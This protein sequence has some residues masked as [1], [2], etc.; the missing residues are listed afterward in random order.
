VR[1]AL[2]AGQLPLIEKN[3]DQLISIARAGMSNLR[4]LV[5]ELQPP[6]LEELGLLGALHKRLKMVEN[7]SGIHSEFKVNGKPELPSSI[8]T[9]LYWIVY[10][11]LS[12]VLKHAEAKNVSLNFDFLG[13][14]TTV[15]LQDDGVGLDPS[16]QYQSNG[17]GL[18]NI[19]NRVE[20]FGGKC[21]IDARPEQGTV[22]RID[23]KNSEDL[24]T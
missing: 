20:S 22:L 14:T 3:L 9:Q 1:R 6:V 2:K 16:T 10:E 24:G 23:F 12:N 17:S 5:F 21:S 19:V 13:D 11:A 15:T 7:R 8:E 4:L 18:K